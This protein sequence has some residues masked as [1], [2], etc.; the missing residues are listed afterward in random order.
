M[1]EFYFTRSKILGKMND[2]VKRAV[3]NSIWMIISKIVN[4]LV[5]LVVSVCITRYLGAEQ[6][7]EMANAQAISSFWG[8]IA[9]LGLLDIV[10]SRFSLEK[11]KSAQVAGT[12]MTMMFLGGLSAFFLS[13]VSAVILGVNTDVFVYVVIYAFVH[14]FQCLSVC[15]YWFYS[16]SNSKYYAIAQSVVHLCALLIS[17]LGVWLKAN[18]VYF[19]VIASLE[20][21]VMYLSMLYCYKITN[22]K[23]IGKFIFDKEIAID[24]LKL[25]LPMIVMGFATTIYMKI[26]QI[27][28]G[29]M[30]GNSELGLYSVAVSLAEYWYFIPATIYSSYLPVITEIYVNKDDFKIR[31]QQLADILTLIGYLAAVG[32][33]FFG[34]WGITFLYGMEFEGAA[35]ILMIYIWS[36]VFTC[37][38]YSGQAFYIIHKDTKTIMW[39]NII[40]ALLNVVLN[41]LLIEKSGSIGAAIATLLQYI[42]VFGGQMILLRKKYGILYRIQI[43]A[44]FPFVRLWKM[45]KL[46]IN[47]GKK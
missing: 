20:M 46:I 43:K 31:L 32:V 16:N 26:D 44:L 25:S 30:L 4:I 18:L 15:E 6:K 22:C 7:G 29:K 34:H 8:F 2:Y 36:G 47:K 37:I 3:G 12:A 41:A 38:S 45:C 19:V 33:M 39:I 40:G 28:V 9:S 17:F 13:I 10:I 35:Y 24:F 1:W 42:I 14:I 27:M 11:N 23:F 21:I 5:G